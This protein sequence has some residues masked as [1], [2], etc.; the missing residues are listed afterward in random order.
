MS[1]QS[2]QLPAELTTGDGSQKAD[3]VTTDLVDLGE[4][5]AHERHADDWGLMSA[6]VKCVRGVAAV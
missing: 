1:P 3:H 2:L 6:S 5:H 4:A